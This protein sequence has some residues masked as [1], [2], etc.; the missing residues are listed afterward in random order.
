M[1]NIENRREMDKNYGKGHDKLKYINAGYIFDCSFTSFV[2][3]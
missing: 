1:T 2:F 3:P